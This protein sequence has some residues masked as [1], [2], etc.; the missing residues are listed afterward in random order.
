MVSWSGGTTTLLVDR[1]RASGSSKLSSS[2]I[3]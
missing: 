3:V 1:M 2:I